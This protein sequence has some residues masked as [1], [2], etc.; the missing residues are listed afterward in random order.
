MWIYLYSC[1]TWWS[2]VKS[3]MQKTWISCLDCGVI[4][5]ATL[6]GIC[7]TK[8]HR[9]NENTNPAPPYL[10]V[11]I[12]VTVI[13]LCLNTCPV[14]YMSLIKQQETVDTLLLIGQ[15]RTFCDSSCSVGFKKIVCAYIFTAALCVCRI[16]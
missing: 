1:P 7:L 9:Q 13:A 6:H 10:W 11:F 3:N 5:N 14:I 12:M 15:T 4:T 16:W 2:L 8:Q